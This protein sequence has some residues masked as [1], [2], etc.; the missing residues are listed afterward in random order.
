[1][2]GMAASLLSD[3]NA[4]RMGQEQ[5]AAQNARLA[6][7]QMRLAMNYGRAVVHPFGAVPQAIR[8]PE[9]VG[10]CPG[11]GAR[12]RFNGICAYCGGQH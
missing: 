4:A 11:C 9:P 12:E 2:F 5:A 6:A 10:Q 8:K 3:V 1:M 7:E